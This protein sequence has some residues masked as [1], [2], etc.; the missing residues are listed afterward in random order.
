M[1]VS[2]RRVSSGLVALVVM[3]RMHDT[4]LMFMSIMRTF[5]F[6]RIKL[7]SLLLTSLYVF[8]L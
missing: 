2:L 8:I 3:Q 7:L 6:L 1:Y 5:W 4:V